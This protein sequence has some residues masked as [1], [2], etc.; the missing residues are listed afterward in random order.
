[1]KKTIAFI[2]VLICFTV[3]VVSCTDNNVLDNAPT[4]DIITDP[5]T[6]DPNGDQEE[7]PALNEETTDAPNGGDQ[8]VPDQNE[9]TTTG[10]EIVTTPGIGGGGYGP[11][12][13][14]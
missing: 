4:F 9:E 11:L 3:L 2:L 12:N 1:M 14:I 13:P 7:T 6:G 10:K 8:T 5:P